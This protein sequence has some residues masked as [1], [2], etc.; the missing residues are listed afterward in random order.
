MPYIEKQLRYELDI[1]LQDVIRCNFSSGELNYIIT[2]ILMGTNPRCYDEYNS[3]IGV[4]ECCKLEMYRR[5]VS[6][7]EQ[8]KIL[9]NGDLPEYKGEKK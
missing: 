1:D 7:Y 9:E 5:A 6:I 3:L 8:K 2:R 4:L